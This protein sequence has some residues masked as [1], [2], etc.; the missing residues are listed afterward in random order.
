MLL[1][2]GIGCAI[3]FVLVFGIAFIVGKIR[4]KG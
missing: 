1:S 4:E 3:F 2:I